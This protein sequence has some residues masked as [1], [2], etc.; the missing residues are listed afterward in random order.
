MSLYVD[1]TKQKKN[2]LVYRVAAQLKMHINVLLCRI[3]KYDEKL[4]NENI[5][6][7]TA[8]PLILEPLTRWVQTADRFLGLFRSWQIQNF[9]LFGLHVTI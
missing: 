7:F 9:Q 8:E 3:E 5:F 1:G 6:S 2:R 4:R